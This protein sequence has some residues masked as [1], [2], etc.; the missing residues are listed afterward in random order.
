MAEIIL[1][2]IR[3]HSPACAWH[4]EQ[5]IAEQQPAAVLIEGPQDATPLIE[6]L[7]QP[8]A[9][10]PLAIY[11]TWIDSSNRL[12]REDFDRRR[13]PRFAAYYPLADFSPELVALRAGRQ[14]GAELAFIDLRFP[15]MVLAEQGRYSER[16]RSLLDERYL[17]HSN[18]LQALC[19]RSGARDPDD[20]WDHLYETDVGG[21]ATAEF[22]RRVETYC[23][24]A[25][26]DYSPDMLAAE[27]HVAREQAMAAAIRAVAARHNGTVLVVTG[28]FHTP[29]LRELLNAPDLVDQPAPAIPGEAQTLLMR[30][31]FPQLD[32][33]NGY[34]SGMPAP[35]FYQRCWE[36]LH[37]DTPGSAAA[38]LIVELARRSRAHGPGLSPA[39]AI[40][41]L[42]QTER[43]AAFRGHRQPA[44]EDLLDGVRSAFVKG[45]AEGALLL[46]DA[47]RL[48]AG[49]RLGE[50][51]PGV[52][53]AP[54]LLDFQQAAASRRL[55]LQTEPRDL[56]LD[57]YRNAGHRQT[58]RLLHRLD[59]L[60]VPFAERRAGP[61]FV[62]GRDL[63]RV[64]EIW[65]YVWSP[66]TDSVLTERSIYGGTLEEACLARLAELR[67]EDLVQGRGG[68]ADRAAGQLLSA[69]RMG[70]QS[71][72][73]E[74][75]AHTAA[76][77]ADDA[78]FVSQ[79]RTAGQLLLLQNSREP[80][81]AHNLDGLSE[82]A[83]AAYQ[84]AC[85]L[86]PSLAATAQSEEPEVLD[87]LNSLQQVALSLNAG[88][89]ARELRLR[90]LRS[91]ADER[92]CS[93]VIR[94]AAVGALFVEGEL[95]ETELAQIS[96]GYFNLLLEET[97][98]PAQTAA[99]NGPKLM[100]AGPAFL[101][102]LLHADRACLWQ[103]PA[104]LRGLN[105]AV[106]ELSPARFLRLLPE[107]RLAFSGLSARECDDVA[108]RLAELI[109]A[110]KLPNLALPEAAEQDLL[111]GAALN[112]RLAELLARDGLEMRGNNDEG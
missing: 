1:F 64:Q 42:D 98:D 106:Q 52:T 81:E 38:E 35:A 15:A 25:R 91:L 39:D 92:D 6:H 13:P 109:G 24:L 41:A 51:P 43:L 95:A 33:L 104:L 110:G 97:T 84:R 86:L 47:R 77:I 40:A 96:S 19:E 21:V 100:A 78:L 10:M 32:R 16:S 75:L 103:A 69:C 37:R 54:L 68:R 90:G 29:G 55:H 48:L 17:Q 50:L 79:V 3:H 5:L 12:G 107:L 60:D 76:L 14:I 71:A 72:A 9:R 63:E 7:L 59:F 99:T 57:L 34:A 36:H 66:Q 87:A 85:Y 4:I 74:L 88:S 2:P 45:E 93:A 44:R 27:G 23:A 49:E 105:K 26:A 108:R 102:G 31:G 65:R 67:E 111:L 8:A 62:A 61:D 58:S 30:Y 18:F 46:A 94:G 28:G 101:R 80:L 53:V 112:T 22:M 82:V 11:T 56:A 20:L 73:P 70:L 83:L 89:P